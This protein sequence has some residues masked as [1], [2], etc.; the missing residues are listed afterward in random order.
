MRI[1]AALV[2][3]GP[4]PVEFPVFSVVLM[5]RRGL[6]EWFSMW[7]TMKVTIMGSAK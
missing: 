3:F 5:F 4:D 2:T 7:H 6:E 1:I